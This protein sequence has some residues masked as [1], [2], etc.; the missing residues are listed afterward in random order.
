MEIFSASIVG[1][2]NKINRNQSQ[3]Y[4]DYKLV[5]N[6]AIFTVADGH[7]TS[8]FKYSDVGAKYACKAAIDVLEELDDN[9]ENITDML[10]EGTIQKSIYSKWMDMVNEHYKKT[11]PVVYKT[12]YIRYSTTLLASL[13]TDTFKM[14][15]KLG[16]GGIVENYDNNFKK[17]LDLPQKTIVDSLGRDEAYRSM[18]YDL[19]PIDRKVDKPNWII[20]FTDGYE[21]SYDSEKEVF[22]SLQITITKYNSNIFSKARLI[23][24]YKNYLNKL[25][26]DISKDDI[27]IIFAG[28]T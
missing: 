24:N 7:S 6:G 22:E 1:Y 13:V 28:L 23:S 10:R 19:K 3:D 12:E 21:N 9:I 20:L 8:Y 11:K 15:L 27:S 4:V 26:K 2:K 18:V 25:S 14:Y 5:K 17:I 16:D